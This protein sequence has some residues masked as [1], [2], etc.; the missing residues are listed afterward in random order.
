[1]VD[2]TGT[3]DSGDITGI[4]KFTVML[5]WE[6]FWSSMF[7]LK[8]AFIYFNFTMAMIIF[9]PYITLILLDFIVYIWRLSYEHVHHL[10]VTSAGRSK[11]GIGNITN[12]DN[13]NVNTETK[14]EI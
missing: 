2:M 4:K 3:V 7:Y 8:R 11:Q 1:M 9:I 12:L 10:F 5:S 6:M 13:N 14:K